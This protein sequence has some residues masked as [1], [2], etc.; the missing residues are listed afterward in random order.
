MVAKVVRESHERFDVLH[1]LGSREAHDTVNLVP[2]KVETILIDGV[3]TAQS[4]NRYTLPL[5]TQI[6]YIAGTHFP[7]SIPN[8]DT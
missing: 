7:F 1:R 6:R 4:T 5:S 8:K 3:V 2:R